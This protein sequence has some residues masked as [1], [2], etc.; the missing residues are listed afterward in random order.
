MADI[1]TFFDEKIRLPSP[2]TVAL[3]ILRAVRR[4]ESSFDDLAE[5]IRVDP[6]LTAQVLKLANSSLYGLTKKV[7]SISQATALIGTQ[8]LKNIA[9]SFVFVNKFKGLNE[10]LFDIELF[11]RRAVTAAVATQVLSEY[12]AGANKDIFVSGLLQDIGVLLL[13]IS[14]CDSYSEL[15]DNKRVSGTSIE[16]AEKEIF[17]FDHAEVGCFLLGHWDIPN[18]ILGPIRYHHV[19]MSGGQ[20]EYKDSALLLFISD[21]IA[22]IYHGSKSSSKSIEVQSA[23]QEH[24]DIS[25][26][27]SL[28]IID[29]IGIKA[30][31][32]LELFALDPGEMK[33]LS[34]MIQEA[35]EELR[36]L[37]LSYEQIVLELRQAKK[38]AEK[39]ALDLKHANDRL[40]ELTIR[41]E[42][43]GLFNHRYFQETL[44]S[45]IAKFRRYGR[46]VALLLVDVDFFK[47]INDTNGHLAGDMVLKELG[48]LLQTLVRGCDIVARYG[49][50]EFGIILPETGTVGAKVLAQRLRRGIEQHTVEYKESR[51]SVTVSIGI[52]GSDKLS[53]GEV[54]RE[55]LFLKGDQALYKAK[56]NGR[57]RVET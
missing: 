32:V 23:L 15:L 14:D 34:I 43:T 45:E 54:S 29:E 33:P 47:K 52:A 12:T 44:D 3:K 39:L 41:D 2:P 37:N 50:E 51:I 17:G 6:A 21:K 49:G 56:K 30:Q 36:R 20:K 38:N 1:Q 8:T 16:K 13:F 40:R 35:N 27:K 25:S 18:T 48:R 46:D 26:E 9:L 4:D 22:A 7:D 31:E 10:G 53:A 28:Q 19:P 24:Y 57:N 42:L 55:S 5:I 11:W